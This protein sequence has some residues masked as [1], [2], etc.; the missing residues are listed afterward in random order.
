MDWNALPKV[1][2]DRVKR[3]P[4]AKQSLNE[5]SQFQQKNLD[6][7]DKLDDDCVD[8]IKMSNG[9]MKPS[10]KEAFNDKDDDKTVNCLYYTLQCCECSI[11]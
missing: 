4:N 10:D 8:A 6:S 5:L 7:I 3:P 9:K 1:P 2:W 11:S